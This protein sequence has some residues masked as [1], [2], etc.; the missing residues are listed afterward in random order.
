[1]KVVLAEYQLVR[2][3]EVELPDD[4]Q[5][6]LADLIG[7][8]GLHVDAERQVVVS[9]EKAQADATLRGLR[10]RRISPGEH[11][12]IIASPTGLSA[13]HSATEAPAAAS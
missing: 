3:E 1:M 8:S 11:F 13:N 2:F 5:A 7:R 9:I 10:E 4:S 6:S 12:A